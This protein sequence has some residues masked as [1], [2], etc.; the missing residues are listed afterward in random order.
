MKEASNLQSKKIRVGHIAARKRDQKVGQKMVS[1][2]VFVSMS[3]TRSVQRDLEGALMEMEKHPGQN[4]VRER[5][6]L[7]EII[8]RAM[9]SNTACICVDS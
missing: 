4:N 3:L 7:V 5:H 8:L 9:A 1:K 2:T 6:E